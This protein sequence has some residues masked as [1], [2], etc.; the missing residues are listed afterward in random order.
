MNAYIHFCCS[1]ARRNICIISLYIVGGAIYIVIDIDM[2][3]SYLGLGL[4]RQV[5]PVF[6]FSVV[7]I[8]LGSKVSK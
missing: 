3:I 5:I 2:V 8:R 6:Q 7:Y 4:H 1:A